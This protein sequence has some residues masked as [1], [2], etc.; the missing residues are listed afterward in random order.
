MVLKDRAR[1]CYAS[2][3]QLVASSSTKFR[4]TTRLSTQAQAITNERCCMSAEHFYYKDTSSILD[5]LLDF[6]HFPL[7]VCSIPRRRGW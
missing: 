7:R 3:L 1:C 5:S 6:L 4:C 2:E